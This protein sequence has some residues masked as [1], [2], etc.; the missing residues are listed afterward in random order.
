MADEIKDSGFSSAYKRKTKR[1]VNSDGSYNI[2]R[3]GARIKWRDAYKYLTE[4]SWSS[5]FGV[6]FFAYVI[7]NLIF[8]CLYWCIGTEHI[9]GIDPENGSTFLQA[10]YFSVQ[11]FTTVGYGVMSPTGWA[12]QML[13]SIEAFVG[14]LSFSLA[15][16]LLYGRFSKP[17]SKLIFSS[18]AIIAP[19]KDE[20]TSLQFK[21]VNSRDN[22][23]LDVKVRMLLIKDK[24]TKSGDIRKQYFQLPLEI[25]ELGLLPLSWTVVHPINSSSPLYG[26]KESEII[27]TNTEILVLISGFDEVFSQT[28]NARRSYH[29]D[30]I[31]WGKKFDQIFS[32]DDDGNIVIDLNRINDMQSSEITH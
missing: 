19:Y 7:L 5:F 9:S 1:I 25:S 32:P 3:K 14:F 30:E 12:A 26:L 27:N 8:T 4:K 18:N 6:L 28:I 2:I 29:N 17:N 22:V 15:T 20:M 31:L 10:Y 21:I 11:T 24:I 13:S 23:L 16:G